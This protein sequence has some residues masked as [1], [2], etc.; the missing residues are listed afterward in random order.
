[1][2]AVA[3]KTDLGVLDTK[4]EQVFV[5]LLP[6]GAKA[7]MVKYRPQIQVSCVMPPKDFSV[8]YGGRRSRRKKS[9]ELT[10]PTLLMS[11]TLHDMPNASNYNRI[12][13]DYTLWAM[14]TT[15]NDAIWVK[16]YLL[17]NV[18][19]RGSICFG[20]LRP[21]SLRQAYNYYWAS[22]FN[23]DL[24]RVRK[25]VC[26]KKSHVYSWHVG[27]LCDGSQTAH[28]CD[29]PKITHHKHRGCGCT[30]V[31]ASKSCR[32]KCADDPRGRGANCACCKAIKKVQ[33][34]A[35]KVALATGKKKPLGVRAL[36]KLAVKDNESYPD[37]GCTWR[38]KRN[39]S[40]VTGSCDCECMCDCCQKKCSHPSCDCICCKNTC[41][42][43][44]RCSPADR[45]ASHMKN[46]HTAI[47]PDQKWLPRTNL[48]CGEKYW[49]A[50]KGSTGLLVTDN[51][52]LLKQI[53]RQFWKKGKNGEAMLIALATKTS[54][55]WEFESGYKFSLPDHSV[56]I[57]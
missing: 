2:T 31:A 9:V 11:S 29:C 55:G 36:N 41:E 19:E 46:Y 44:C 37:C 56:L 7:V 21:V 15:R 8:S 6:S 50:P 27:C 4:G 33:E 1:M 45:F 30:T 14:D 20:A 24:F 47:M 38:H 26:T 10:T 28:K 35:N 43:P 17:A 39:C 3:D 18:W 53:P 12:Q 54:E 32:G 40:C 34:A 42:C 22:S 16:P 25:H 49:A 13:G 48:F 52:A 23:A 5:G 51:R 57:K